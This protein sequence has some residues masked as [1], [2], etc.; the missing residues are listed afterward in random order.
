MYG[1][2][3]HERT[4]LKGL[5]VDTLEERGVLSNLR[6]SLRAAVFL[7]VQE[8]AAS[9]H[10]PSTL[11]L[12]SSTLSAPQGPETLALVRELLASCG[13]RKTL[14]VF[15]A[16]AG[17]QQ[18]DSLPDTNT[19]VQMFGLKSSTIKGEPLLLSVLQGAAGGDLQPSKGH[20]NENLLPK[21]SDI[22]DGKEEI[23]Q[24]KADTSETKDEKEG[25]NEQ[26][27]AKNSS[28][29][30]SVA[31]SYSPLSDVTSVALKATSQPSPT[32][33]I[34]ESKSAADEQDDIT[35]TAK[36]GDSKTVPG[37]A[38]DGVEEI[39]LKN[40]RTE[41]GLGGVVGDLVMEQR[42]IESDTNAL[43]EEFDLVEEVAP[44]EGSERDTNS[45]EDSAE[46][47]DDYDDDEFD[48]DDE[49]ELP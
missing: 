17:Q 4:T 6:A 20:Q 35:N 44:I 25:S 38:I 45:D 37:V 10:T 2:P 40:I 47:I 34:S 39:R 21:A 27:H 1:E 14:S 43:D 46:E 22:A 31:S 3:E 12:L 48:D 29:L 30:S 8:Q 13:M 42:T 15:D 11:P 7:A 5:V 33:T 32:N 36:G 9:I 24:E 23:K 19:A 41:K 26:L 16:E 18:L 49:I 28:A